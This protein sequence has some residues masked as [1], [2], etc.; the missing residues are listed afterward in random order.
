MADAA[1]FEA[2][3]QRAHHARDAFSGEY[4]QDGGPVDFVL[5]RQAKPGERF[6]LPFTLVSCAADALGLLQA[7]AWRAL[8]GDGDEAAAAS[9]FDLAQAGAGGRVVPTAELVKLISRH[10]IAPNSAMN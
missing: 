6:R 2:H 4:E 5:V 7:L 10:A 9:L 1:W 3:P 8:T